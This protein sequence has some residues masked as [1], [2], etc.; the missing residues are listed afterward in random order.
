MR[1]LLASFSLAFALGLPAQEQQ[2]PASMVL[3]KA[4]II[5]MDGRLPR[6]EAM[7]IQGEWI[8]AVGTVDEIAPYIGPNTKVID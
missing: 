4:K 5:T 1:S 7:A 3:T 2:E 8:V 6:A